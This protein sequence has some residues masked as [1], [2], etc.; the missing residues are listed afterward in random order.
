MKIRLF[1]FV[2]MLAFI[3]RPEAGIAQEAKKASGKV[4]ERVWKKANE[5]GTVRVTVDLSVPGW[6][7]KPPSQEAELAQRQM[8]ADTQEKVIAE[9]TGTRHKITRRFKIVPGMGLEV[10]PEALA[11]LE[12]SPNVVHVYEDIGI[13]PS[14]QNFKIEKD[15]GSSK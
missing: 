1:L 2:A 7:S 14:P 5:A 15:P 11:V 12:R 3:G 6:T 9:L 8:I 13:S 10:G 4:A